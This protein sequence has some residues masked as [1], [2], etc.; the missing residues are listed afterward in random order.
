MS[1]PP[2]LFLQ[3]K[4]FTINSKIRTP[5][6]PPPQSR[7]KPPLTTIIN[8]LLTHYVYRKG[9]LAEPG[10]LKETI[11]LIPPHS[12]VESGLKAFLELQEETH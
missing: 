11:P 12:E 6:W 3:I 5:N 1:E 4:Q 8:P 7:H 10:N 2:K 9:K